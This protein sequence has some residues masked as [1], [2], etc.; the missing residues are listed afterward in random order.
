MIP[1]KACTLVEDSKVGHAQHTLGDDSKEDLHDLVIIPM[2]AFKNIL[3][4]V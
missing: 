3:H 2:Y 1:S 4:L